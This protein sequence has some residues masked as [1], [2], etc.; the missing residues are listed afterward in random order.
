MFACPVARRPM[1][2]AV[3]ALLLAVGTLATVPYGA[4]GAAQTETTTEATT[5]STT[6][7]P[8]EPEI[9]SAEWAAGL[10]EAAIVY[11]EMYFQIWIREPRLG[12]YFNDGFPYEV[13]ATCTAWGVA[14]N[15][16]ATAA[17]C[18]EVDVRP[19]TAAY[20]IIVGP[21][22]DQALAA[23]LYPGLTPAEVAQKGVLEWEAEGEAANSLPELDLFASYGV[24]TSGLRGG[25]GTASARVI[26]LIPVDE[27]DVALI[28]IEDPGSLAEAPVPIL[29][30]APGTPA[31]GTEILSVGYPG[32][33]GQIVSG[34]GLS[35]STLDGRISAISQL[36][37]DFGGYQ[38]LEVTSGLSGGMSGG[39]T[40]D[41]SG[42]VVGV[43]SFLLAGD[44]EAFEYVSP[45]ERYV[46]ELLNRNGISNELSLTDELYRQGLVQ[47]LSGNYTGA[48]DAFDQLLERFPSHRLA[49]EYRIQAVN[50]RDEVGDATVPPTTTEAG[51]TTTESLV[52]TTLAP[53]TTAAGF[54]AQSTSDDEDDG[55]SSLLP[56]AL[57][58][59]AVAVLAFAAVLYMRRN[60][61]PAISAGPGAAALP[62]GGYPPEAG[63]YGVGQQPQQVAPS[64]LRQ[65]A[66]QQLPEATRQP[67]TTERLAELSRLHQAG[68]LS[69]AEYAEFKR[70]L[71]EEN[72]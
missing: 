43:N 27:G 13:N 12:I 25:A 7:P 57:I 65:P 58:I 52:T 62:S 44:I 6:A 47:Y 9:A 11:L 29:E 20:D 72:G 69:D 36:Q 10:T 59:G 3:V 51:V 63:G 38:V 4:A 70:R 41:F 66:A 24:V 56:I 71:L 64:G 19:G 17:H 61:Q 1:S 68:E 53:A 67:N 18:V 46:G 37:E 5:T 14:P 50:L 42:R 49:Q 33:V 2:V 55:S 60:Q 54:A 23:N 28:R 40:V 34:Q 26:D 31:I 32:A 48:I 22:T 8:L 15:V 35:P 16:L 21:A 45:A 39:P 30:V